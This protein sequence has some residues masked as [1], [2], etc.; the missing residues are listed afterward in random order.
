MGASLHQMS[1]NLEDSTPFKRSDIHPTEYVHHM[2]HAWNRCFQDTSL[3]SLALSGYNLTLK[4]DGALLEQLEH[5]GF[6]SQGQNKGQNGEN[7]TSQ[8]SSVQKTCQ[9]HSAAWL[10]MGFPADGWWQ[11][12][13]IPKYWIASGNVTVCCGTWFID[14]LPNTAILQRMVT[15]S[16]YI[17]YPR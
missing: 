15:Y 14:Y 3:M 12:M 13:I 17:E 6:E 16:K 10:R 5:E 7:T 1:P 11:Y 4:H 2:M 8:V 9:F